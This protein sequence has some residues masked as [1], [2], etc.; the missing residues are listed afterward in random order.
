MDIYD[1][2]FF[3]TSNITA[4]HYAVMFCLVTFFFRFVKEQ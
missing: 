4:H 1:I 3:F 2:S